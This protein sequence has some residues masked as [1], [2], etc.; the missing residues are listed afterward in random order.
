VIYCL[1]T[2]DLQ[3]GEIKSVETMIKNEKHYEYTQKCAPRVDFL[4]LKLKI[5]R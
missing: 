5:I 1:P 4:I 3:L 2:G